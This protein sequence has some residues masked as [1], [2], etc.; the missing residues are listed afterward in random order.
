M[1]LVAGGSSDYLC[2]HCGEQVD[3]YADPGGGTVQDY[4]EDC[5]ICCRPNHVHAEYDEGAD[6]FRVEV[7]PE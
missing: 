2:P 5:P 1:G 4:V 6:E 7:T 3:T